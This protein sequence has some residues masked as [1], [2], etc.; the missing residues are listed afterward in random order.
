MS[1]FNIL[2][3]YLV[4]GTIWSWCALK[5]FYIYRGYCN[6]YKLYSLFTIALNC[7][8]FPVLILTKYFIYIIKKDAEETS[9][10][11]VEVGFGMI[12]EPIT[13]TKG[14]TKDYTK[15]FGKKD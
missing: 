14:E 6:D 10:G 15:T 3:T 4:L 5:F 2:V 7:L 12:I 9:E 8:I 13:L 1:A 11:D